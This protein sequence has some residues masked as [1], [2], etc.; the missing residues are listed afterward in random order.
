MADVVNSSARTVA[1]KVMMLIN[2]IGAAA[3]PL[4]LATL[5]EVSG[6]SKATCR[7]LLLDLCTQGYIRSPA[8]GLY[9]AGPRLHGLAAA[10]V[11]NDPLAGVIAESLGA[12][13]RATGHVAARVSVA[14]G[15]AVVTNIE[16][17]QH[18][19]LPLHLGSELPP[20]GLWRGGVAR[21]DRPLQEYP[22][23]STWMMAAPIDDSGTSYML[24]TGFSFLSP[25]GD[26]AAQLLTSHAGTLGEAMKRSRHAG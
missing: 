22:T 4:R 25:Q 20:H 11:R 18:Q 19:P 9:M 5:A 23:P 2:A 21:V 12:L 1:D 16:N 26:Q 10:V 24:L 8:R 15:R 6:T 14:D 3:E 7:R 13:A 17:P